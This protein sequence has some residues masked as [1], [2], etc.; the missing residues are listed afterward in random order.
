M[1][2]KSK[3]LRNEKHNNKKHPHVCKHKRDQNMQLIGGQSRFTWW[4]ALERNE[5][6]PFIFHAFQEAAQIICLL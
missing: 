2:V 6:M 3:Y 1:H 4:R 5:A